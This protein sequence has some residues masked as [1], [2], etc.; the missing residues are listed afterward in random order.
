MGGK[1]R[2]DQTP[3][4][5]G[6]SHSSASLGRTMPEYWEGELVHKSNLR[7]V[8]VVGH[9]TNSLSS[10]GDLRVRGILPNQSACAFWTWRRHLTTVLC[11]YGVCGPLL[12]AVRSLYNNLRILKSVKLMVAAGLCHCCSLSLILFIILEEL[13]GAGR[14]YFGGQD[15]FASDVVLLATWGGGRVRSGL[16]PRLQ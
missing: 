2:M 8:R 1:T 12:Q 3:E 16:R 15:F 13:E 7:Y 4:Y 10:Q 14:L 11:E 6:G 5:M 9:W